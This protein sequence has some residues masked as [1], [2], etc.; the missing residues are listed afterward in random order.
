MRRG[1]APTL[2]VFCALAASLACG[3]EHTVSGPGA[4]AA[5]RRVGEPTEVR[6]DEPPRRVTV[7][8]VGTND[9]HGHIAALP[10]LAGYVAELREERRADGGAVLLVDAGDMFQGTLE[11]NLVEGESVVVGM[12]ELGYAAAAVGN[13]EFDYGPV[14]D[15]MTARS[16][17][18][19]PRGV[20]IARAS[21]A[22]FPFLTANIVDASTGARVDWSPSMPATRMLEVAG[23][24]IG[25]VGVATLELPR[26]TIHGNVADIRMVP[27]AE[28]IAHESARLRAA[29]ATVVIATA[30]AGG[31]CADCTSPNDLSSCEP[32]QEIFA[33]AEALPHGAVDA[34]VAGHTHAGVAHIVSG[35]PVIES[36]AYGIAFGRIDLE[37]D[38][39]AGRVVASHVYPPR[40]LCDDGASDFETCAHAPYDGAD[41]AYDRALANRL[42]PYFQEAA[43]VESRDLGVVVT[44]DFPHET[45]RESAIGNL[46]A[47]L[48]REGVAGADVG[49]M[50]GGGIRAP[51]PAGH[52]DYG[53]FYR[54]FP[55]DNRFATL[56]LTGRELAQVLLESSTSDRSAMSVSGVRARVR[57]VD[58]SPEVELTRANGRRVRPD[59]TLVVAASDFLATGGSD[60]LAAANADGRATL[61]EGDPM[62]ERLVEILAR[63]RRVDPTDRAIFDPRR[64]RIALP[65]ERPVRC[66]ASGAP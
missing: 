20:L 1:S 14:G 65:G 41:V 47:D 57:C 37:V 18:D 23:A 6:A 8:L 49:L 7:T 21:E 39:V 10:L 51:L 17:D 38:R 42:A 46:L 13:H 58:G 66:D 55:F 12:N 26:T 2:L 34:I 54:V 9:L 63:R 11:S 43:T 40:F 29:G 30:H 52:L 19:D 59:E 35:V 60:V 4:R 31:K 36:Y 27:L 62:R 64:P 16:P 61:D 5:G 44:A 56:R 25:L 48:V 15:A 53:A 32:D 50:N 3:G 28:T 33:V 22:S 24:R 45:D